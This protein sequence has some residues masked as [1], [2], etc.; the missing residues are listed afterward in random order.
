MSTRQRHGDGGQLE[1]L[2]K[3]L[4]RGLQRLSRRL[5]RAD[6]PHHRH[7]LGHIVVGF[8]QAG[9]QCHFGREGVAI[10]ALVEPEKALGLALPRPHHMFLHPR[11]RGLS[12]GLVLGRQRRR[13]QAHQ[14][15]V[16]PPEQ[17]LGGRVARHDA[18]PRHQQHRVIGVR[19]HGAVGAQRAVGLDGGR[20][21]R[22]GVHAV[23]P[24]VVCVVQP[25]ETQY[26]TW[27][28]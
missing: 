22:V 14:F 17:Q 27:Q 13:V 25:G 2:A 7:Q 26:P 16:R 3:A 9:A 4:L 24:G 6:I 1:Q 18:L 19:H 11:P 20:L 10:G 12:I 15:V 21:A 28:Q 23:V 5:R 8:S